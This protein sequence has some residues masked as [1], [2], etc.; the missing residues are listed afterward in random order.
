MTS[1]ARSLAIFVGRLIGAVVG[2]RPEDDV[3]EDVAVPLRGVA[4]GSRLTMRSGREL[5]GEDGMETVSMERDPSTAGL[6]WESSS[7]AL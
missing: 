7:M 2:V 6:R 4:R 3:E 5:V 1:G